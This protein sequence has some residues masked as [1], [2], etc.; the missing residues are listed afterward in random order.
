MTATLAPVLRSHRIFYAVILVAAGVV[1]AGGLLAPDVLAST[2]SWFTLPPLHARF[3]GAIYLFGT[4]YM[5]GCVL[6]TAQVDVRW[7]LPLI[8]LFTGLLFVVSVLNSGAF[9]LGKLPVLVWLASYIVYPLIAI[10]L[11]LR[12]PRPWPRDPGPATLPGWARGFLLVQGIVVTAIAVVLLGVPDQVIRVWPWPVTHV[13][14]QAYCG[15]LLAYGLGSL[16]AS[17][18]RTA[19][20]S[21]VAIQDSRA[22]GRTI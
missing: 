2:F 1:A 14:A 12:A 3:L 8:A 9:D 16:L 5:L 13:L 15:P 7:A 4:V 21:F 10:W 20:M 17:Q 18:F 11:F 19:A 6:A 22:V